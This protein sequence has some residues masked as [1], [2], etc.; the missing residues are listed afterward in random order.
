MKTYLLKTLDDLFRIPSDRREACFRELQYAME[1]HS[2]AFGDED[3]PP[4]SGIEWTDDGDMSQTIYTTDGEVLCKLEVR[5][6]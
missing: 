5:P 6:A 2:L 4:F 1:L 3:A